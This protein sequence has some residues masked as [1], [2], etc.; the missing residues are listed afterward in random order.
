MPNIPRAE[1][2]RRFSPNATQR[3]TSADTSAVGR[4]ITQA[5]QVAGQAY[6][7]RVDYEIAQARTQ[8]LAAKAKEDTAYNDDNE[9]G[10]IQERYETNMGNVLSEAASTI[11][12]PSARNRFIQQTSVD[13]AQGSSRIAGI[14]KQEETRQQRGFIDSGLAGLRESVLTG[15]PGRSLEAARELVLTGVDNGY[16]SEEEAGP[17]LRNWSQESLRAR[18]ESMEPED[19]LEALSQ[20]WAESMPTDL[21]VKLQRDAKRLTDRNVAMENVDDYFD[22]ELGYGEALEEIQQI[23]DPDVRREAEQR[24][25]VEFNRR[26]KATAIAQEEL[27]ESYGPAV[28]RGELTVND[29]PQED[30]DRMDTQVLDSLYASERGANTR[31]HSDRKTVDE[32]F[33]LYADGTGDPAAVREYFQT[34]SHLLSD[35]DFEQWSQVSNKQASF[36][37][38]ENDPFF[39][40]TQRVRS[41]MIELLGA[42][43]D[44]EQEDA[45]EARMQNRLSQYVYNYRR[46]NEGK[47]P[48]GPEQDEFLR[49]QFFT[50]PT[51]EKIFGKAPK[52]FK[53]WELMDDKEKAKSLDYIRSVK[54]QKY[55]QA[56]EL[57]TTSLGITEAQIDPDDL[58][59]L[60]STV[61]YE[62]L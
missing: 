42:D 56:V 19:R 39:T 18:I 27:F 36:E 10:T 5:A 34:N 54:P 24:F 43:I 35:Q 21:R 47:D 25:D 22:R 60:L 17:L 49:N 52:D 50:M 28:R 41:Y 26:K 16:V 31:T 32:L 2:I 14:A 30:L 23:E 55:R 29:I 62:G 11:S 6:S 45:I 53:P 46:N 20:P 1:D 15:D 9:Y 61:N 51:K 57:I 37:A 59:Q 3:V 4:S 58:A 44:S 33:Q 8:F 13:M 7:Q 38:I 40:G 12:S 48:S